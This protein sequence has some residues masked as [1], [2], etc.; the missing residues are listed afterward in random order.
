MHELAWVPSLE[1]PTGPGG[2]MGIRNSVA[3][4]TG[5][6]RGIGRAL[7]EALLDADAARIYAAGRAPRSPDAVV[8]L[9]SERVIPL[10][11]DTTDPAQI[12]AAAEH[13]S[14]LNLLINNAGTAAFGVLIDS[15]REAITRD[16]ETNYY[17]TLD[18]VR[19]FAPVLDSNRPGAIFNMITIV[20][21]A[22]MPGLGGYNAS[23]AAVWSLTQSIRADLAP[24]GVEVFGVYPGAVDTDMIRDLDM[25][26]TSPRAIAAAVVSG[27][28]AGSEDIF[29]DAMSA[30]LY[31]SW[32]TDHKSVERQFAELQT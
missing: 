31:E 26:K 19:A 11:L 21:L 29:P 8:A 9:D 12:T 1:K 2:E 20:A 23:K 24:R 30:E 16:L 15:P 28:E 27:I 3:L 7:V 25:P 14:D 18:M 17:G 6:N 32:R 13:A 10:R 5:S 22:S 4:V